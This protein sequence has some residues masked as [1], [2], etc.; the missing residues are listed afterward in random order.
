MSLR[1]GG[2]G[3]R[4]TVRIGEIGLEIGVVCG[5]LHCVSRSLETI[6]LRPR[7]VLGTPRHR[8]GGGT[9]AKDGVDG[10]E[11]YSINI[12]VFHVSSGC[13]FIA[14]NWPQAA[15]TSA[16]DQ[17]RVV[18]LLHDHHQSSPPTYSIALENSVGCPH[19]WTVPVSFF[20]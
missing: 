9:A 16:R 1:V 3:R 17:F 6:K 12:C 10:F 14:V 13:G 11:L 8:C 19:V 7:P 5:I 15:P 2:C 20:R 18:S 4:V